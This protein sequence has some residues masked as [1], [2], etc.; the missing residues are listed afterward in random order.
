MK[1]Y[2]S[3]LIV[4][5]LTTTFSW[6]QSTGDIA[7]VAFNVDGDDDFAI[8][9]LADIPA[10]TTIYFSDNELD[11]MGGLADTNEGIQ[12]W[13]TGGSIIVAG[14]VVTFTDTV[15]SRIA[16]IG[17]L[18]T[19]NGSMNLSG[20]GDALFAYLGTS[21]TAPTTFLAGI[22]NEA[23][24]F[25]DLTG[26]GLVEGSTFINFYT[27]GNPDGGIYN[28][29]SYGQ[30]NYSDFITE[31]NKTSNW[32]VET[33]EGENILDPTTGT[34]VMDNFS[35]INLVW[36]GSANDNDW[37][38]ASNWTPAVSP[39]TT[40][41]ISIPSGLTSYPTV[42]SATS[43]IAVTI[44]SGASL[45]AEATITGY[46]IY[47]RN[48]PTTNWYLVSPP[49]SGES[50]DDVIANH[51]LASGTGSNLGL[52]VYLN[53]T[54]PAWFYVEATT[55][56][57]FTSG[58]G[59]S[60][61]FATAGDL[62]FTGTPLISDVSPLI[63]NGTRNSFNLIG[64]PFTAYINSDEFLTTN[65]TAL[66][67]ATIWLWDGSQYVT[68]NNTSS[69]EIAPTQGFFVEKASTGGSASVTFTASD[70]SHASDTFMREEPKTNFELFVESSDE[71]KSTK[72]FY[73][74]NKT[75]GFDNGYDSK[76]FGDAEDNFAIYTNLLS[77]NDGRKLAIQTL[78]NSDYETMVIPV[79]LVAEAG[80]E[81]TFSAHALNLPSGYDIYLKDNSAN[82]LTN[83]S[84][85]DYTITLDKDH[86]GVGNFYLSLSSKSLSASEVILSDVSIY[87]SSD[88]QITI[89]GVQGNANMTVYSL[90]GKKVFNTSLKSSGL[91]KVDLPA[92]NTG[93]YIVK[94]A[95]DTGEKTQKIILE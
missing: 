11:G 26:S 53:N 37:T 20:A 61:K 47:K 49:V 86:D 77:D 80:K 24:N 73:I 18:S 39:T 67:E 3:L 19:N 89:N 35:A 69:F 38:N 70:R 29:I 62:S 27:S 88:S 78:P 95:S 8:V 93:V 55:I 12:E 41:D 21:G 81:I 48:L 46:V 30:T 68:Y 6:G 33:S 5:L 85:T 63:S 31:L 14:T 15:S 25:G 65:S 56:A 82:I 58:S 40:S 90:L 16:S 92:L 57:S 10:N 76:M 91:S 13:S 74:D 60:V 1:H 83:L 94:L 9:A 4:F 72:I 52:A 17:T 44:E 42:S 36:N 45:I 50:I 23:G 71:K 51:M 84:E 54:G 34:I 87:K 32:I 75:T 79:G 66:S 64:N 22:Q 7:F 43:V 59:Y 28:G 2:Y